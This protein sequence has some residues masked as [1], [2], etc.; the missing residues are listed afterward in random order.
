MYDVTKL[1]PAEFF[2]EQRTAFCRQSDY[3]KN[4]VHRYDS[5]ENSA[6]VAEGIAVVILFVSSLQSQVNLVS[7]PEQ[8]GNRDEN[9]MVFYSIQSSAACRRAVSLSPRYLRQLAGGQPQS[10]VCQT[11]GS[12]KREGLYST[13]VL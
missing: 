13:I 7:V 2:I 4:N 8:N 6:S 5:S 1:I 3:S 9:L 12:A 11:K 10:K